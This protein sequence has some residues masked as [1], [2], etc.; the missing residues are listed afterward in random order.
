MNALERLRRS[1][2]ADH[3]QVD[4]A[5]SR[6]DLADRAGYCRFLTVHAQATFG[7]E[8]YL[9]G[10]DDL[11]HW[12]PRSALLEADLAELRVPQATASQFSTSGT[13]ANRLGVLYVLEGSRLGASV[14][15][16][17]VKHGLP[18]R[19]LSARHQQREWRTLLAAIEQQAILGGA[20]FVASLIEGARACFQ[21]Y[22]SA[23]DRHKW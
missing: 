5:F 11:P 6:F 4:R 22:L 2:D 13:L 23:A 20:P 19:Y 18:I 7:V 9:L 12:R 21:H 16:R 1:T 14:L 15:L 3:V 8:E 10:H 17:R